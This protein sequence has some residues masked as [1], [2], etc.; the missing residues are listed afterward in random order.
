[1]QQEKSDDVSFRDWLN[2]FDEKKA[3]SISQVSTLSLSLAMAIKP[4]IFLIQ[5][6]ESILKCEIVVSESWFRR[7]H[8]LH[9]RASHHR[10]NRG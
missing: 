9:S 1:L 2:V 8:H 10:A 6:I 7:I 4:E 5:L 3:V